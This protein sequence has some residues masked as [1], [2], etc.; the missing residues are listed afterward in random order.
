MTYLEFLQN[1]KEKFLDY[2]PEEYRNATLMIQKSNKVN[3]EKDGLIV[4]GEEE[5]FRDNIFPTIYV[6]DMYENYLAVGDFS[7]VMEQAAKVMVNASKNVP[8]DI[9][10]SAMDIDR[11]K[12]N[13][14]VC[15]INT[16]QNKEMLKEVPH[17]EFNDLSVIYRWIVDIHEDGVASAVINNYNV[18]MLGMTEP[19]LYEKAMENTREKFPM[20]IRDM[21][22]LISDMIFDDM[23]MMM[24]DMDVSDIEMLQQGIADILNDR[25]S[26]NMYVFTNGPGMFGANAMLFEDQLYDFSQKFGGDFYIIPSSIHDLIAVCPEMCTPEMLADLVY[27]V[28]REQV[29]IGERL[30]NEVY[31][32]DSNAREVIC[33]TDVPNKELRNM[34]DERS[35]GDEEIDKRR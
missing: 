2:M 34:K 3:Q 18:Q 22:G 4:R 24:D 29:D 16:E 1:V 9:R 13:L 32:Y 30:S 12:S 6:N 11:I 7:E 5:R 20:K 23:D 28:N 19:E 15:L 14:I 21:E 8:F 10:E 35:F 31:F 26:S 25:Y 17:R 33:V 27:E